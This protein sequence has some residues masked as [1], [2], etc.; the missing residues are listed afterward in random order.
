MNFTDINSPADL[1]KANETVSPIEQAIETIQNLNPG[2]QLELAKLLISEVYAFH[3]Y[4]T[5]H[6]DDLDPQWHV[7]SQSLKFALKILETVEL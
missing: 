7:D 4:V 6:K 3:N 2:A 1:V 5:S